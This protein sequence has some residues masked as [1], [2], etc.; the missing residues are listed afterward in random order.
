MTAPKITQLT[1]QALRKVFALLEENFDS[2]NGC[3]THNFDDARIA[4]ETGISFD[5]VKQYRLQAFGKLKPP[6]EVHLLQ[7]ELRELEDFALKTENDMRARLKDI[8]LRLNTLQRKF[9]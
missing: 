3:Y 8:T 9:D 1:G 7:Q 6:S 5:A 2:E 4:K